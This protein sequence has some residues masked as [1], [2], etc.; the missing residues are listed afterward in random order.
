[1][2]RNALISVSDKEG[3][4]SFATILADLGITIISSGG[5]ALFLR[6]NGIECTEVA[7]WTGF[8]EIMDGRVKTLHPKIHGGILAD[9]ENEKHLQTLRELGIGQI[10]LVLVNLYPFEKTLQH[11]SATESEIIEN[12]DIGGPTLIRAAAKNHQFVTV[13]TDPGDYSEALLQIKTA[14]ETT[15]EFRKYLA[16]KAFAHVESYD[17]HISD[18]F[19]GLVSDEKTKIF[20]KE[21]SVRANLREI[22]RYGENPHQKAAY[23]D[24]NGKLWNQL[25]GKPLS[26]N[27]ILDLD[28]ALKG[29]RLFTEPTAIILKHTNPCGIGSGNDLTEA[30]TNAFQTDTLS[31]FGGI[32]IVNGV[33]DL[34][35]AQKINEIFTEIVIAPDYTAEALDFLIK[36]KDRR[37]LRYE[38]DLLNATANK[39][40]ELKSTLFGYLAQEWD[41]MDLAKENW[42]VVTQQK[43]DERQRKALAF[44][45]KT[46]SLLKSNSIALTTDKQTLGL[47][48]GQTSR[49]DSTEIAIRKALSFYH[50]LSNAVCA[51][52]G[53]FPFRDSVQLLNSHGIKTVIQP[54]GS[55]GDDD[56]IKACDEMGICMIFTNCRHFR[57]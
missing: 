6:K 28:T 49:I 44:A 42:Q 56:V 39:E 30:Y 17:S 19:K 34:P 57:H 3:I 52:D 48:I 55:K 1:M 14:K 2:I 7:D 53:F 35:A 41:T 22:L 32:V 12:I 25:H 46:V 16:Y 20:P 5:T 54:G 40:Y 50:D 36:K 45:W 9:R 11:P 31:P 43:P 47:G 18:Y 4:D 27:N 29:I 13:L 23:Y 15:A 51:S 24:N 26:F 8:P 10:D 38:S 37:L 21:L 33:L